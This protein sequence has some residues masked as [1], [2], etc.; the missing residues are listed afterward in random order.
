MTA[1]TTGLVRHADPTIRRK[2]DE[3]ASAL[4]RGD[5]IL[6]RPK[7]DYDGIDRVVATISG[8]A[9]AATGRLLVTDLESEELTQTIESV[10]HPES[11]AGSTPLFAFHTSG[12]TGSPKCVIYERPQV[13]SHADAVIATLGLG[14][15]HNYVALPPMRFAYGSSIVVSH[16]LAGVPVTFADAEWGL[17]AMQ[18]VAE[19]DERPLAVYALPQHT[20]LLLASDLAPDRLERLLIAGGRLSGASA[21][22]LARRFPRMRLTNMYGQA[23]MGPRLATWHGD[24]ADFT[25]GLI[26][27]PIPGV[28]LDVAD[29]G[30]LLARSDHAMTAAMRAPYEA[31]EPFAGRNEAVRT[32]DRAT[33][34]HSGPHA[35]LLRHDGRADHV[36][37]VAG[38]KVDLH[39]VTAIVQ[40]VTKP[41]L[42]NV[43]TRP[44]RRGGDLVPVVEIVP[45]GPAPSSTAPVRRALHTEFGGLAALFDLRYVDRLTLKESGK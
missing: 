4:T 44:A 18:A 29:D 26:G 15:A 2:V 32:G 11:S 37:N 28:D 43:G 23:E 39:R 5:S 7:A 25:E 42:V 16:L 35:G 33:R 31:M 45:N 20:P 9:A 22:A 40:E 10:E 24:P 13:I 12:S 36:L 3:F 19:R 1:S 21:Q 27:S 34:L 8:A 17:P 6:V 30:V 38:T 41:L 14:A